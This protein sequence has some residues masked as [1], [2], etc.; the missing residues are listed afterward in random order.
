MLL[1][2]GDNRE[3]QEPQDWTGACRELGDDSLPQ[4]HR[5][6]QPWGDAGS[7]YAIPS[8]SLQR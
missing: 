5:P 7:V 6:L 2:V 3:R 1:F 4:H 8:G